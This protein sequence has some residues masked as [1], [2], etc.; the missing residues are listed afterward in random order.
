VP[1]NYATVSICA[2]CACYAQAVDACGNGGAGGSIY[3]ETDS[4]VYAYNTTFSGC[5]ATSSGAAVYSKGL[6]A[7]EASSFEDN[8]AGTT[9]ASVHTTLVKHVLTMFAHYQPHCMFMLEL[10]SKHNCLLA[11]AVMLL[12]KTCL[13][14]LSGALM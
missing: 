10:Y 13:A 12:Q 4:S 8:V 1:L 11:P 9:R 2:V 14:A 3:G 7:V 5:T 6:L